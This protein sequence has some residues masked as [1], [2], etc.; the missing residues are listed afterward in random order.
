MSAIF[1]FHLFDIYMLVSA[2]SRLIN[3]NMLTVLKM[4]KRFLRDKRPSLKSYEA[5]QH[6]IPVQFICGNTL[7][8]FSQRSLDSRVRKS[9][10][11]NVVGICFDSQSVLKPLTL[12]RSE[13]LR[14]VEGRHWRG[15]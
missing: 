10:G 13:T 14:V 2:L 11:V 9:N 1:R 12:A 15:R 3:F 4:H 5:S 8:S 6:L 7:Q